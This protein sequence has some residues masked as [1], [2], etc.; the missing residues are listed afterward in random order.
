MF[1][2]E[3]KGSNGWKTI[4]SLLSAIN[5]ECTFIIKPEGI[6]FKCM[7][8]DTSAMIDCLWK[9]DTF[10]KWQVTEE[11]KVGLR[12]TDFS[13]IISRVKDENIQM[14]Q[15]SNTMK[16]NIGKFKSYDVP[17]IHTEDKSPP[18][19][20]TEYLA[21]FDIKLT[22]LKEKLEDIRFIKP[23]AEISVE[24]GKV[25][26]TAAEKV[27]GKGQSVL[28]LD[29]KVDEKITGE[30]SIDHLLN[31]INAV[32]KTIDTCKMSMSN[33]M[34]L[35]AQFDIPNMGIINYYLAPFRVP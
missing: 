9:A 30:Y 14:N 26:F 7:D 12:L 3:S 8:I 29:I 23:F 21:V 15:D 13:K 17:L 4:T 2:I 35:K 1:D 16:I 18:S 19:P 34:P 5:D 24:N 25:I 32:S 27:E 31:A 11:T 28:E 20:K 6:D 10:E 33:K 22:E